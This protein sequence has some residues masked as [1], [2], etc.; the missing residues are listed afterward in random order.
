VYSVTIYRFNS[1][2]LPSCKK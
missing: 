1:N 2:L